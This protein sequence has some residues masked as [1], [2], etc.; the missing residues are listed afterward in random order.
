M[1]EAG[2]IG[3]PFA[4]VPMVPLKWSTVEIETD[5]LRDGIGTVILLGSSGVRKEE[6]GV[7]PSFSMSS[8]ASCI[9]GG[10]FD[11][12]LGAVDLV[13]EDDDGADGDDADVEE[14]LTRSLAA[15]VGRLVASTSL[16]LID[17]SA[18]SMS[19]CLFS[20]SMTMDSAGG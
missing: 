3:S 4:S 12:V 9:H 6:A 18:K 11:F 2:G 14:S 19:E 17:A 20:S 15:D 1:S 5:G 10:R 16:K 13:G 8:N 7:P